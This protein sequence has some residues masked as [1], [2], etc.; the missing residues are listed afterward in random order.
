MT[1]IVIE[2]SHV[3]VNHGL[4]LFGG[5]V[6]LGS[7]AVSI[8]LFA[9]DRLTRRQWICMIPIVGGLLKYGALARFSHL[10]A[11]LV[12]NGVPLP[13]AL[14]LAG[15]G[16]G[17]AELQAAG[18]LIAADV[19]AGEPL[20]RAAYNTA[21]VPSMLVEAMTWHKQ[22]DVFADAL[23]ALSEMYEARAFAQTGL[24]AAVWQPV[25]LVISGSVIG[26]TVIA[27]FMPLV[28]LLNDLS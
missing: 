7:V 22:P 14:T 16:A 15:E 26:F 6:L 24:I 1:V 13:A 4:L 8:Y 10:L 27:L 28:K 2:V 12:E 17:D 3:L 20:D 11:I 19:E 18:W 21:S 25:V 9:F 23:R 5:L